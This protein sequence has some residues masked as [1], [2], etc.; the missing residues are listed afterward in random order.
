MKPAPPKT[1]RE[2]TCTLHVCLSCRAPGSPREPRENRPG[3]LFYRELR[4]ALAS[5]PLRHR[6]DLQPAE[7]L[8]ICPRP[9]GVALSSDGAWTYLFGD[10]QPGQSAGD[11]LDCVSLYLETLDGFMPRKQRPEAL[12]ASILGRVPPL[13]GG[14]SCT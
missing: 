4:E 3:S 9:C 13:P 7:C 11:V 5:S 8:S 6:V 2:R 1:S 10:Q 12:R 14:R